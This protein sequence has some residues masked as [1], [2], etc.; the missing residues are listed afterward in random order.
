M[1]IAVFDK[2]VYIQES[3][4]KKFFIYLRYVYALDLESASIYQFN[5]LTTN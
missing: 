4:S 2:K 3:A 5:S 1:Q